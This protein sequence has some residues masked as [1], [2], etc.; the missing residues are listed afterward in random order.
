MALQMICENELPNTKLKA[1]N[2]PTF[3]KLEM[4]K[5]KK[6]PKKKKLNN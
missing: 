6:E 1:K 2:L 3:K 5:P 4:Q